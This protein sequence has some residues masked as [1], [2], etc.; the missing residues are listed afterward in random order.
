MLPTPRSAARRLIFPAPPP[1]ALLPAPT[2]ASRRLKLSTEHISALRA[3]EKK[4]AESVWPSM[5]DHPPPLAP[6]GFPKGTNVHD[7]APFPCKMLAGVPLIDE[8]DK[9]VVWEVE[10]IHQRVVSAT[11]DLDVVYVHWKD[12]YMAK[13]IFDRKHRPLS[14]TWVSVFLFTYNDK[15][16]YWVRWTPGYIVF[17]DLSEPPEFQQLKPDLAGGFPGLPEDIPKTAVVLVGRPRSH[18]PNCPCFIY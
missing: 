14:K 9:P 5:D 17:N 3:Y 1:Q 6:V 13:A 11:H 12:S 4:M 7:L 15:E 2:L 8:G 10:E 16:Y 18:D